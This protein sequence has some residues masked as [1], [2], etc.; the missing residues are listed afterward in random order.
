VV[1]PL[2]VNAAGGSAAVVVLVAAAL[3]T[4][5]AA[6]C[7]L[8]APSTVRATDV[9]GGPQLAARGIVVHGLAGSTPLPK[10]DADTWVLADLTTGDVLAAKGAHTRVLPASTLKTLTSLALMPKLD[11]TTVVTATEVDTHAVGSHVGLVAGATYTVWDLWNGLLLPSANDAASALARANG[12]FPATVA[13]MQAVATHLQANDTTPK[14]PSGLDTPGQLSSAYDMALMARAAMQIPDFR[15][16]TMTKHYSFPGKAASA[17]AKRSTY[18]ISTENRLLRH[19]YPGIAGGKTG[20]TSLAH[21]TFW[22]TATRGGHTL[23]VTLFQIHEPTET[24]ARKLL[25]WGFANRA[26]VAPVGTLVAPLEAGSPG[27]QPTSSAIGG[28]GTTASGGTTTSSSGGISWK[29]VAAVVLVVALAAAGVL[30]WRRRRA[31]RTPARSGSHEPTGAA[32]PAVAA[33]AGV[34]PVPDVAPVPPVGAPATPA[35]APPERPAPGGN[36][37]I[38]T[39]P[40]RPPTT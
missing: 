7:D 34:P 18:Q 21:R 39:P 35:P 27:S 9:V 28:G 3:L 30:W 40:G 5:P 16:I 36:V 4:G 8:P 20:F 23:V 32:P 33:P 24:A 19:N 13:D 17:G 31:G 25:D 38:I 2:R 22:A 1:T 11:R 6:A 12:G 14:T 15:T 29:R 26:K 10:I 37:R